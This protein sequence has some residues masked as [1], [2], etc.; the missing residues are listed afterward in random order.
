MT[1]STQVPQQALDPLSSFEKKGSHFCFGT[2]DYKNDS[3]TYSRFLQEIYGINWQRAG[4]VDSAVKAAVNQSQRDPVPVAQAAIAA[5]SPF[6][7][8]ESSRRD[9]PLLVFA[10]CHQA[11]LQHACDLNQGSPGPA[12]RYVRLYIL[13]KL[14]ALQPLP[15]FCLNL[16]AAGVRFLDRDKQYVENLK[17]GELLNLGPE[18]QAFDEAFNVGRSGTQDANLRHLKPATASRVHQ[19]VTSLNVDTLATPGQ[20]DIEA[21]SNDPNLDEQTK[22]KVIWKLSIL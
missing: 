11:C 2:T 22:K 18:M 13:S 4:T 3:G 17:A 8:D 9:I 1:Q 19:D 21:I 14:S 16:L 15:E 6:L 12:A 7:S 5:V 10:Y 20:C